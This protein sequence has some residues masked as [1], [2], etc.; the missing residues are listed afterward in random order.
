MAL[1]GVSLVNQTAG[2][3]LSVKT[4]ELDI[5]KKNRNHGQRWF[6]TSFLVSIELSS[7]P[8]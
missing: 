4:A 2:L 5:N 6:K 8:I 3:A 7:K 1:Q